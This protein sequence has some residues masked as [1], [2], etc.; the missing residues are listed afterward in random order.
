MEI[1]VVSGCVAR[2]G[3]SLCHTPL[4]QG[5]RKFVLN[6]LKMMRKGKFQGKL[7]TCS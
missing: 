2:S 4:W 1:K 7:E 6:T 5:A 3:N